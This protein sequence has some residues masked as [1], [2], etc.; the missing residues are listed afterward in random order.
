MDLEL[1]TT[2]SWCKHWPTRVLVHHAYSLS[3]LFGL[4]SKDWSCLKIKRGRKS[5]L[6]RG[7][8]A[9]AGWILSFV[10]EIAGESTDPQA[11]WSTML[12]LFL[13]FLVCEAKTGPSQIYRNKKCLSHWTVCMC[14]MDLE[15]G[16]RDSWFKHWPTK[17][18]VH[19]AQS[20][21]KLMWSKDWSCLKIRGEERV[22]WPGIADSWCKHWPTRELVHHAYSL[23]ELL[24]LW[25]KDWS[26]LKIK[27]GRKSVLVRGLSAWAEWTLSFVQEIAGVST[28]PQGSCS[29]MLILFVSSLVCEAKTGPA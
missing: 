17:E 19:H 20:L 22:F 1:C 18:L 3:E 13:S 21:P 26:C 9:C 11:R 23:P 16:T 25:S 12:I 29:T 10:Q 5:V 2:D 15:L 4:W 8:S 28:G 7:L 6:A 27:R 14:W 24:G